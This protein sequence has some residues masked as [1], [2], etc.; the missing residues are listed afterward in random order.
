MRLYSG[1]SAQFLEDT[2]QNKIADKLKNSFFQQFQYYP[3]EAEVNSWQNSLRAISMLFQYANLVDHGIIL[4]YQLPQTS[5][6]LDCLI[7]GKN[8][9]SRDN[10]VIIELKQWQSAGPS[11]GQR[12]LSTWVGGSKKDV[13]HPSVQVGQYK[14]YLQDYHTAFYEEAYPIELH[15]CS[16]LHNYPYNPNDEIYSDKFKDYLANFPL[17]TKDDVKKLSNFLVERLSKGDGLEV[18]KRI[19]ASKFRPSK[20][21]MEHIA[22]VVSGIREYTLLDEQLVV[23]DMV[24]NAV[25]EGYTD[26]GKT[27]LIVEGGPGTGKSV[28]AMNLMGDLSKEQYNTHYVTGSRA[29]TETIRNVLGRR[30]S[31]QVRHFNQYGKANANEVDVI[32]ADEAHRMWPKNMSRFTRKE[33]RNDEPIVDQLIKASKVSVFFVDN[34]Q[35]IRPEEVGTTRYIEE[36]ARSLDTKVL[37]FKLEAQFRCQGS[38]AFVN[39]VNNTLEIEKTAN[40]I[41]SKDE[42]F[43]FRIFETPEDLEH[44]ILEKARNG[45]KARLTAGFCWNWSQPNEDGTL[46]ADVVIGDFKRPWNAKSNVQGLRL[47]PNI[48]IEKLWAHDPNGINQIGCVYTA[49]GFE[50][51]YVGVIFGPDLTYNLDEQSW[52][53]DLEQSKDPAARRSRARYLELVK[54]TYRVLL[55]RGM[56]GC[57]VYFVDKNTE[58]FFKSRMERRAQN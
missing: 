49:Q 27:A 9:G 29:F 22:S 36:H 57:Y 21:L 23:Y 51:D 47:A 15:A 6:R 39:W 28:I 46:P 11:M 26:G 3:N 7:C 19:E 31:L 12:E 18:L 24:M 38:D 20:K 17:F 16:Y 2:S 1:T 52:K 42:T 5:K 13:L 8:E 32:I 40:V 25:K 14:E 41:W 55:S 35:V 33:D 50:F 30:S 44:A 4:E 56:E 45:K 53:G 48:P 37:K 10:A 34:Y 54:N 43:D 58:R